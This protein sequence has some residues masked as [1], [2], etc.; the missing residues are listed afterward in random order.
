MPRGDSA[1]E[2]GGHCVPSAA[3]GAQSATP[4]SFL[5]E[6]GT[7]LTTCTAQIL[8]QTIPKVWAPE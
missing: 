5:Q 1:S 7:A 6:P 2:S 4:S 8:L 3:L